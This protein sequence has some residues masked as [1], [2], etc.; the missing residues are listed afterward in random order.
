MILTAQELAQDQAAKV[1]Q[2]FAAVDGMQSRAAAWSGGQVSGG[3][4]RVCAPG[5]K[6]GCVFPGS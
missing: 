5:Q 2:D 3:G 4:G 6:I 1:A